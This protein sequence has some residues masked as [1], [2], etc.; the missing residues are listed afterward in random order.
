[1]NSNSSSSQNPDISIGSGSIPNMVM[2]EFSIVRIFTAS[3]HDQPKS[4]CFAWRNLLRRQSR[5]KRMLGLTLS[6][7]GDT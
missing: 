7:D 3:P 6:R 5:P 2:H 4:G 1:M